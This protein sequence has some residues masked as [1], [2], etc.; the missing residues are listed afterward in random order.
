MT[1]V[2]KDTDEPDYNIVDAPIEPD[3]LKIPSGK[4]LDPEAV[5]AARRRDIQ[6]LID[7]EAFEW[8]RTRT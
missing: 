6:N 4:D 1:T 7:F 5:I 2:A 8:V 3:E